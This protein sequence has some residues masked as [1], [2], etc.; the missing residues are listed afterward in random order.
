MLIKRNQ[1]SIKHLIPTLS[2]LTCGTVEG[3]HQFN[4]LVS[5]WPVNLMYLCNNKA[6]SS[7]IRQNHLFSQ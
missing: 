7:E 1:Q 4:F 2:D 3:R 6:S 5:A